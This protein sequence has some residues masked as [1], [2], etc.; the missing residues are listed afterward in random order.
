MLFIEFLLLTC[1]VLEVA[2]HLVLL[3]LVVLGVLAQKQYSLHLE[4]SN[5]DTIYWRYCSTLSPLDTLLVQELPKQDL[6]WLT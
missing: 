1:E 2:P 3:L 5:I 6:V 4:G